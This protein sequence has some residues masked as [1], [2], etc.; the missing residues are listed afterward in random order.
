MI[1]LDTSAAVE[2][3]RGTELGRALSALLLEREEE[4][5]ASCDLLQVEVRSAMWKY[6]RTK[7]MDEK[8]AQDCIRDA[9]DLV[10]DFIPI[11]ELGDEAFAEAI[12]HNHSVYDMLYLCLARRNSATLFTLDKKLVALC[13]KAHVSCIE[14]VNL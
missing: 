8:S 12:F 10:D 7:I 3:A 2:I 4:R 6:V 9:L 5:V 11:E 1:V 13:R 14:M